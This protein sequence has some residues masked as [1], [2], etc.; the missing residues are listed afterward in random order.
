MYVN[1]LPS[2]LLKI[3]VLRMGVLRPASAFLKYAK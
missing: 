3:F 1:G 2:K